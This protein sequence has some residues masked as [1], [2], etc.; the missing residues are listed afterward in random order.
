M[1]VLSHDIFCDYCANWE[2][3]FTY[4][5]SQK[6]V[7]RK[8]AKENGWKRINDK[9]VCPQCQENCPQC[10]GTG[11]GVLVWEGQPPEPIDT[12]PCSMCDGK[13]KIDK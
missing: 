13:G 2:T 8:L 5:T 7:A 10:Q 1:I 3:V 4:E 9:D 6:N 11:E 12:A